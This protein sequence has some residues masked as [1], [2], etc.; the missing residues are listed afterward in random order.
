MALPPMRA[1][2]QRFR[3]WWSKCCR[4]MRR[5]W[6]G[7]IPDPRSRQGRRWELFPLLRAMWVGMLCNAPSFALSMTSART[8]PRLPLA[9]FAKCPVRRCGT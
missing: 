8:S 5:L 1:N 7:D 6:E 4:V 9:F 3:R 2:D